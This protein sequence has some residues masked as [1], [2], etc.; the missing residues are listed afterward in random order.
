MIPACN[1]FVYASDAVD[2][3][4]VLAAGSEERSL[5]PN[6]RELHNKYWW[7]NLWEF[8]KNGTSLG[9]A[10][11]SVVGVAFSAVALFAISLGTMILSFAAF[12]AKQE[13][14]EYSVVQGLQNIYRNRN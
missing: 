6:V 7:Q 10:I 9:W 3:L 13:V 4:Q 12:F 8:I 2:N 5:E 11:A 1:L 14:L